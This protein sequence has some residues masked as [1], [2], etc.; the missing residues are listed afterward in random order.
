M[1][2]PGIDEAAEILA[3][4]F[5]QLQLDTVANSLLVRVNGIDTLPA[6]DRAAK[7]LAGLDMVETVQPYLVDTGSVIFRVT[8]RSGRLALAQA[9]ALGQTL[10]SDTSP[11]TGPQAGTLAPG[12]E[13][14]DSG[15]P[16]PDTG[17]EQAPVV[18]P[19]LIPDLVYQLVP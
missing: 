7:Y 17:A 9:V 10:A 18:V 8:A 5:A 1:L 19:A 6:Y 15:D 3:A 4:R 11:A 12:I 13:P 2:D 16:V 14:W